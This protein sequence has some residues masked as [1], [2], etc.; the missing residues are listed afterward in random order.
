VRLP[1][2]F[3][4]FESLSSNSKSDNETRWR[5]VANKAS[6]ECF[7]LPGQSSAWPAMI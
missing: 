3:I 5:L 4:A 2:A 6:S 7:R 1:G